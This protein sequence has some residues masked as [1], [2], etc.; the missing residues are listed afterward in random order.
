[1]ANV[2]FTVTVTKFDDPVISEDNTI[3]LGSHVA[4]TLEEVS[5]LLIKCPEG[6]LKWADVAVLSEVRCS[7]QHAGMPSNFGGGE[8]EKE[9]YRADFDILIIKEVPGMP[10]GTAIKAAEK[11]IEECLDSMDC[12]LLEYADSFSAGKV[13]EYEPEAE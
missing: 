5:S 1:M 11:V 7:D 6:F 2:C 9:R 12:D 13:T 10:I 8:G 4:R 3:T